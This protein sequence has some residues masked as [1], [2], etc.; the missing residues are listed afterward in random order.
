MG[1]PALPRIM[2]AP[3]GARRTRADHPALPLTVAEIVETAKACFAAGAGG[4]HAHVRDAEGRHVLDTGLY[5]ELIAEMKLAVP[6][7][8]VQVTTEAAGRYLPPVQRAL[9]RK[10]QPDAVSI[11]LR[12]MTSDRDIESAGELYNQACASGIMVQHIL[13][14]PEEI[15]TLEDLVGQGVIPGDDLQLLFVLGRYTENQESSPEDLDA[16]VNALRE[17]RL[18]ADWAACAFGRHETDCLARAFALGGKARVGFENNF[19]NRDGS[20]AADNAERVR[21]IAGL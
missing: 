12:E 15:V 9:V 14:S 16:F 21:E 1:V 4:L 11:A 7:M 2:V 8:L 6:A 17:S 13:Y 18:N 20:R 19:F 3:N 5:R 10:L